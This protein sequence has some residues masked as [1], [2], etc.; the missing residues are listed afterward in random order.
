MLPIFKDELVGCEQGVESQ[1][2]GR[3]KFSLSD[4]FTTLSIADV[5]DCVE[6]R[7]PMGYLALPS[8][9]RGQR[10]DDEEWSKLLHLVEEE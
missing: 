7:C 1:F 5:G 4:H 6:V 8:W 9:K 10:H 3:A 2:L